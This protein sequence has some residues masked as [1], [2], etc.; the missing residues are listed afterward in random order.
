MNIAIPGELQQFVS[1]GISSGRFRS[2]DEAVRE[3]LMLLRNREEKL[4][5]LRKDIELGIEALD[6]G[7]SQPL[8]IERIEALGRQLLVDSEQ[9]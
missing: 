1:Q 7:H 9:K 6:E 5:V 3:G 4:A 8:S 2:E